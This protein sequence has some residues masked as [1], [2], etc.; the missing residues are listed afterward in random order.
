MENVSVT[1]DSQTLAIPP[2]V[3]ATLNVR[4]SLNSKTHQNEVIMVTILLNHKYH[5][6][7]EAPKQI[8]QQSFCC[9]FYIF[10][11]Y[12]IHFKFFYCF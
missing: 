6:D 3:I 1:L 10:I 11:F 7:K 9:M 5:I 12:P 8:F 2:L 4:I